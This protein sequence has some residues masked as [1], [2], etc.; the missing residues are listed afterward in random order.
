MGAARLVTP[1]LEATMGD[2][3][4][5]NVQCLNIDLIMYERA[6]Q[7]NRW[8]EESRNTF[9]WMTFLAWNVLTREK[10]ITDTWEQFQSR[11]VQ[12]TSVQP[13]QPGA[14]AADPTGRDPDPT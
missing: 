10:Q 2:G 7:K 8:P 4:V 13:T 9:T 3:A 12:V 11:C 5:F 1:L 14:D 6:A